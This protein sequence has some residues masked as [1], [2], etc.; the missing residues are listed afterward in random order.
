M[1]RAGAEEYVGFSQIVRKGELILGWDRATSLRLHSFF[2]SH[3][4]NLLGGK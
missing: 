1:G 2:L 4:P 3:P